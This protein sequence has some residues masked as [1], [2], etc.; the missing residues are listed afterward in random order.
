MKSNLFSGQSVLV[1][2]KG[3]VSSLITGI[4]TLPFSL[5]SYWLI[6]SKQMYF[7]AGFVGLFMFVW[8]LFFWGFISKKMWKWN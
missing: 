4:T 3:L 1:S 2:L 5:L 8:Y 6:N 7:V